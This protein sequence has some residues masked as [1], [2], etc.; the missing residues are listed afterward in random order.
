M[1]IRDRLAVPTLLL[2]L[3]SLRSNN[4]AWLNNHGDVAGALEDAVGRALGTWTPTLH[5]RAFVDQGLADHEGRTI[6]ALGCLRIGCSAVYKFV[7]VLSGCLR[8]ELQQR[9]CLVDRKSTNQVND[10]SRLLRRDTDK[11]CDGES[12]R[13]VAEQVVASGAN[14]RARFSAH[15]LFAF[16]SSFSCPRKVRVGANSPNL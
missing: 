1:C 2:G 6:E 14:A 4:V 12:P 5:G 10:P 15:R 9:E 11:A 16:R 3:R 7:D 13:L 8:S